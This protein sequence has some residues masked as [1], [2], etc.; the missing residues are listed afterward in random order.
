MVNRSKHRSQSQRGALQSQF[1]LL[2]HPL[3]MPNNYWVWR[4]VPGVIVGV[5]L[6]K[7]FTPKLRRKVGKRLVKEPYCVCCKFCLLGKK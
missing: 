7:I 4:F 3:L 1:S 5:I 2:Y 6:G